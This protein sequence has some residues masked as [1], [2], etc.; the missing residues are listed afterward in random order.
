MKRRTWALLVAAVA[1]AALSSWPTTG[2]SAHERRAVGS[3]TMRVGWATEP[4]YSG[5][6]N[7]VQLFL[8]DTNG[9]PISGAGDTLKV[10]VSFGDQKTPMLPLD[11]SDER[12]GA[13]AA[14][15]IPDRA[16]NYTFHFV[17][18]V[19]GQPIDQSFTSSPTTFDPVGD[20]SQ[21]QF[22]VKDPSISDIAGLVDRLGPRVDASAAD[23]SSALAAAA[24][25]R[26]FGTAGL[27][28]G[29][30]GTLLGIGGLMKRSR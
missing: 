30:V 10:Q 21:I 13:Y 25:A 17:G 16:G 19:A 4:T 2:A 22:P 5:F 14:P 12:R 8:S 29:A 9:K 23:A 28:L 20:S 18:T 7:A 15:L 3:V 6:M 11:E 24:Q 27:V 26:S 1:A